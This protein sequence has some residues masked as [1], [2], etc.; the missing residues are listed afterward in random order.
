MKEK[1]RSK[2]SHELRTPLNAI[3]GYSE[4]LQEDAEDLGLEE[5]IPDL[6]KISFAGTRLLGLVNNLADTS[7]Y[8]ANDEELRQI[9][10][11]LDSAVDEILTCCGTLADKAQE[12]KMES[13]VSHI[14]KIRSA[15]VRELA[16]L[17]D[18][19]EL[20][21]KDVGEK[22]TGR[23]NKPE[24][25]R[26]SSV[27]EATVEPRTSLGSLLVVDD[28]EVVCEIL[29]HSLKREGY[30]VTVA[31]NGRKALQ[32]LEKKNFD[33]VL[34][35]IMMPEMDGYA[36]CKKIRESSRIPIIFLSA[37]GMEEDIIKGLELEADDY[38][39]KPFSSKILHAKIKAILD[40]RGR[41]RRLQAEFDKLRGK[42][43]TGR[44]LKAPAIYSKNERYTMARLIKNGKIE[45]RMNIGIRM[46]PEINLGS[47][48]LLRILEKLEIENFVVKEE[49][50]NY[51]VCPECKGF[52]TKPSFCCPTCRNKTLERAVVIEH[53]LCGHLAKAD[54]FEKGEKL[55]CPKC[56]KQ[57]KS[58]GV[59]YRKAGNWFSCGN[60]HFFGMPW[61]EYQCNEC[62]RVFPLEEGDFVNL[63]RYSINPEKLDEARKL[64][65][66]YELLGDRITRLGF[67]SEF[68]GNLISDSGVEIEFD[69]I[70]TNKA[71]HVVVDFNTIFG[72]MQEERILRFIAKV[73]EIKPQ[74]AV[75]ASLCRVI[76]SVRNMA[77][78]YGVHVI[79]EEDFGKL[80]EDLENFLRDG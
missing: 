19:L 36:V 49:I 67:N 33:L 51:L 41:Y 11:E 55:V 68:M 60:K 29:T 59:D 3:I 12:K 71:G 56:N 30:T 8:G 31:N 78:K 70:A 38:L 2:R 77:H 4:M 22:E 9:R 20:S 45:A 37:K 35:D 17:S 52:N 14:K 43:D 74:A 50:D 73:G 5:F 13:F 65:L 15:S 69:F 28:D 1:D 47:G 6:Q 42:S 66:D 16:L 27:E 58:M 76:P 53:L 34:L 25:L 23:V 72:E 44:E 80:V 62:G 21:R 61:I 57:L 26:K 40:S 7:R 24:A 75:F 79:E 63:Y 64:S 46:E 18:A 32:V 39:P 10:D 54:A 48:H